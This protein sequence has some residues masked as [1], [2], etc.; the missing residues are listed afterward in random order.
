MYNLLCVHLKINRQSITRPP[1]RSIHNFPLTQRQNAGTWS[2]RERRR[3]RT[4]GRMQ[5]LQQVV[6]KKTKDSKVSPVADM[7]ESRGH[8]DALKHWGGIPAAPSGVRLYGLQYFVP[9]WRSFFTFKQSG[10]FARRKILKQKSG[11]VKKIKERR[12]GIEKK[13][14]KH[15]KKKKSVTPKE[16]IFFEIIK[17]CTFTLCGLH[18]HPAGP[19]ETAQTSDRRQISQASHAGFS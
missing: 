19:S 4:D 2:V 16:K 14:H 8:R 13:N 3:Q 12:K 9:A 15:N 10:L 18:M 5:L 17:F 1:N 7:S 11:K 6:E